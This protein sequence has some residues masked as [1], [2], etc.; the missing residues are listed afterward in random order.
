MHCN[1]STN[2]G[3]LSQAPG[4]YL[5]GDGDNIRTLIEKSSILVHAY[6][7]PVLPTHGDTKL[8]LLMK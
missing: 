6:N 5:P 2:R 7:I 3:I 8:F 4:S 1:F